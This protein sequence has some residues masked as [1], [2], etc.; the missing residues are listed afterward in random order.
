MNTGERF[1]HYG[2]PRDL[3]LMLVKAKSPAEFHRERISGHFR[4]ARV[5]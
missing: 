4:F 2:V 1:Q 5:R 3:A